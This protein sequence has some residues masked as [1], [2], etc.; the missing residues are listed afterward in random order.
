MQGAQF[1]PLVRELRSCM[2]PGTTKNKK[3]L[4]VLSVTFQDTNLLPSSNSTVTQ[5][6][7]R[8]SLFHTVM[9]RYRETPSLLCHPDLTLPTGFQGF[10]L[11]LKPMTTVGAFCYSWSHLLTEGLDEAHL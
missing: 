5:T 8:K 10:C 1:Q 2:L 6:E 4:N 3:G 9:K 11:P 7:L